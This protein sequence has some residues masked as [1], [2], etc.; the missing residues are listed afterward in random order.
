MYI[1]IIIYNHLSFCYDIM[2]FQA[3][4]HNKT[5]KG[6]TI[7]QINVKSTAIYSQNY[8]TITRMFLHLQCVF[9]GIRF[10]VNKIGCRETINFFAFLRMQTADYQQNTLKVSLL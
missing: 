5:S 2:P 6:R 7:T 8:C 3:N 4:C 10:K 9:H 1:H